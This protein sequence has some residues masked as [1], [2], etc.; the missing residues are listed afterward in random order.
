MSKPTKGSE[1][2]GQEKPDLSA[3]AIVKLAKERILLFH[4]SLREPFA[5]VWVK[6]HRETYRI[7]SSAFEEWLFALCYHQYGAAPSQNAVVAARKVLAADARFARDEEEVYVRVTGDDQ[8]IYVDLANDSWEAVKITREGWEIV[9]HTV[10]FWRPPGMKPL[11]RPQKG[12]S[13]ADLRPFL[14]LADEDQWILA[15]SW[16]VGA[17]RPR[18]PFLLIIVEGTHG[19]GKST[20][21]RVLRA[22]IDPNTAPLRAEPE[23]VRDL[24]I[25]AHNSWCLGFDNLSSLSHQLSDALCRLSTGGGFS[26]RELYTNDGE[27]IF[28]G[29]RPVLVNGI[30]IGIE[31]TDLLDRAIGLTLPVIREQDRETEAKF[32]ERFEAVRPQIL[33][34]LYDAVACALRRLPE[35]QP[36]ALPR[37]ADFANWICAAEPALG[38]PEG[39]F[40]A[41]YKRNREGLTAQ[42]LEASPLFQPIERIAKRGPWNGTATEL[43]SELANEQLNDLTGVLRAYPKTPRALSQALR[44]LT[45]SLAQV[46]VQITFSKTPGANSERIITIA[47]CD[48]GDAATQP[49]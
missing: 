24:M 23:S 12:G 34:S 39:T 46:G 47:H 17:L 44:R 14:N 3:T 19:S 41:A 4:T 40:L 42:G 22:L 28:E 18:G 43:L 36:P 7:N 30:D 16:L 29:M 32:W 9:R 2:N 21:A 6:D 15:V 38:W 49:V 37:M 25:S 35:V 13:I 45:P 8:T 48:V 11:P 26:T 1:E 20:T 33:G 27:K 10:K 31:R 5:S